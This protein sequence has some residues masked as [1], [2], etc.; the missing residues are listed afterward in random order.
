MTSKA[1]KSFPELSFVGI[2]GVLVR[3]GAQVTDSANL[4]ALAFHRHMQNA[5]VLG[6]LECA[7]SLTAVFLRLDL[8]VDQN[9]LIQ[10]VALELEKR[11]WFAHPFKAKR[12]WTI[13]CSF[14]GP[15]LAE[16]AALVGVS[17][18]H[19][20]EQLLAAR[21]RVLTIGF[22]PGQ[23]YLGNLE[24]HWNIPRMD[25]IAPSVPAGALVVAVG[26][27]IIF[28]NAAPTGWRHIGQTAFRCFDQD[29]V[30]P[31]AFRTGDLVQFAKA[32]SDEIKE[33]KSHA[34][35][36]AVLEDVL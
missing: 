22:A 16:A 7:P 34:F 11:D 13:P 35:G 25:G 20:V 1:P 9:E 28:S 26:Q 3:F 21:V 14:D 36:G 10:S 18:R 29:R 24:P 17:E 12:R 31:F 23:P 4:A 6:I 2:D 19:A 32:T 27:L 30:D 8:S 5:G 15:K 33:M